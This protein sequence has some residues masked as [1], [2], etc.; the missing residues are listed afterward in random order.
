[1][2]TDLNNFKQPELL[3]KLFIISRNY[4]RKKDSFFEST[5]GKNEL[6]K[7]ALTALKENFIYPEEK[8][9]A[10]TDHLILFLLGSEKSIFYKYINL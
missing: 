9:D 10:L 8:E 6:T 3:A 5:E 7:F 1:M 4:D 2:K